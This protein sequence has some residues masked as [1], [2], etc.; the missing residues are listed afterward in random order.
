MLEEPS[1]LKPSSNRFVTIGLLKAIVFM[2]VAALVISYLTKLKAEQIELRR[3]APTKLKW[4]HGTT[5]LRLQ[6]AIERDDGDAVAALLPTL[7]KSSLRE[8]MIDRLSFDKTANSLNAFLSKG[9]K[10]DGIRGNGLPLMNA[11]E[12]SQP[13][14]LE[15]LLRHG[16]NANASDEIGRS[17]ALWASVSIKRAAPML[18]LLARYHTKLDT[19]STYVMR[20]R[21]E[22]GDSQLVHVRPISVACRQANVSSV[23]T[24]LALGATARGVPGE[25]YPPIIGAAVG[26]RSEI[27]TRMLLQAGADPNSVGTTSVG[28]G[29]GGL[30]AH[31]GTALYFN[32]LYD[33]PETVLLLLKHGA[34]PLKRVSS[35]QNAMEAAT[36]KSRKV[37][38][39]FLASKASP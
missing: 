30:V 7:P 33:H 24:L 8:S 12:F 36:G 29:R 20:N 31:R 17:S 5:D 32:A 38:H 22:P 15:V 16:A 13:K 2:A 21:I 4:A 25:D 35:G 26:S 19:V 11:V 10:A 39:D 23:E 14:A 6:L 28:N 37:I 3:F 27:L 18:K 1:V 34:D 9:W